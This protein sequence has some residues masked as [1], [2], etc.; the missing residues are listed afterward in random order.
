MKSPAINDAASS[1]TTKN[2]EIKKYTPTEMFKRVFNIINFIYEKVFG[3]T[4]NNVQ[5][6]AFTIFSNYLWNG[7]RRR[8]RDTFGGSNNHTGNNNEWKNENNNSDT[9]QDIGLISG[10]G[11]NLCLILLKQLRVLIQQEHLLLKLQA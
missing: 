7:R 8:S 6:I 2:D 10:K 11:D 5:K 3:N 1:T 4:N 9:N